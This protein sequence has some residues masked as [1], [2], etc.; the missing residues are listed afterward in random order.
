M[1][2]R[3]LH[4]FFVVLFVF[5]VVALGYVPQADAQVLYGSVSGNITD[6]TGAAVSKA[7]IVLTNRATAAQREAEAD[8]NGHFHVPDLPPGEYDLKVT[9]TGFK[10]LTQT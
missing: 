3:V 10:P 1:S 4:V 8:E 2:K 7:H 9:S 5:G 6:Q